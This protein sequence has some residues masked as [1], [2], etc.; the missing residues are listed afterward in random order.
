VE[1]L[2]NGELTDET[3]PI[4]LSQDQKGEHVVTFTPTTIG[5][6]QKVEFILYKENKNNQYSKLN[7]WIDV[8]EP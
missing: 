3:G 8:N 1:V 4:V 7:L 5:E 2:I 6:K